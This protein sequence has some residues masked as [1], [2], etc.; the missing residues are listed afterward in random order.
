MNEI[1]PIR[2]RKPGIVIFVAILNFFSAALFS[3]MSVF[4]ALLI[5]FGAAWGVD[6]YVSKQMTQ[7]A[8]TPNFSYG[9]TWLFGIAAII[10]FT[11]AA[12]FMSIGVGLLAGKK[13]AWYMQVAMS[14]L[15]LLGLPLG[16]MLMT[17]A[18]PLGALLNISIL[19]FFFQPRTRD[20]FKV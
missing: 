4:M 20:Y 17:F 13:F 10:L 18:L 11:M 5:V 2:P 15:G 14:A 9:L 8:T 7:Y 16:V 1:D 6:A 12:Y 19:V 3:M